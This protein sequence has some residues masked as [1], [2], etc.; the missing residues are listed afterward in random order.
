MAPQI[1]VI[2]RL[3]F[4]CTIF[5]VAVS[6]SGKKKT[7]TDWTGRRFLAKAVLWEI[8]NRVSPGFGFK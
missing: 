7:P 6:V 5:F 3:Y 4:V 1:M 2:V 8:S